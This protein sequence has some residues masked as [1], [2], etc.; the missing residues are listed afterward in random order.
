MLFRSELTGIDLSS[1]EA[2]ILHRLEQMGPV[3]L[4]TASFGQ[5]FNMTPLQLVSAFSATIN[6][7]KLM[8]P[9]ILSQ[10]IDENDEIIKEN[11]PFLRRQVISKE[12]SDIVRLQS[13][14]V[15]VRGTGKF[16]AVAGY[17]VGG[18]TGTAQKL[19]REANE[20]IYSF[21]GYAPV[22]NPQVV[23]LTLFDETEEYAEGRGLAARA[24]QE[25]ME[26]ILPYLGIQPVEAIQGAFEKTVAVPNFTDQDVYEVS[27]ML[28]SKNL[29]YEPIGVGKIIKNQ[30]PEPGTVLPTESTIKLYFKSAE[31]ES[32]IPV[33]NFMGMTIGEAK[34]MASSE[35]W[36]IE[37]EG[38]EGNVVGQIP[39]PNM[40]I[41]KGS[42]VKL[43]VK[44]EL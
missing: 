9:Y 42:V 34:E 28:Q 30:Y 37:V 1:E 26:K 17:R 4:A 35:Q 39:K 5:T 11:K 15:V 18:K 20:Y 33:P 44:N 25:M 13:E 27:K 32:C 43:I 22:E 10:V 23:I 12:V 38:E 36:A 19:P 3:E 31:P 41:E 2:G 21:I 40:K 7:G 8:R 16:A 29:Y 24:F 14:S 6:G